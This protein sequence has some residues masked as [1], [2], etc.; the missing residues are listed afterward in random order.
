MKV[1]FITTSL[2]INNGAGHS[3]RSYHI[4]TELCSF[5][6]V[7]VLSCNPNGV[8]FPL[9]KE[10]R[11]VNSY[12]GHIDI[13]W[14]KYFFGFQ[15]R[16]NR[17]LKKI[18]DTGC[19]D[20]IFIRYYNTALRLGALN[21]KNLILDC[22]DCYMELLA[23]Q[24]E[25]IHLKG[26]NGLKQKLSFWFRAYNY[27]KN[28]KKIK[29]VFFAKQ[30]SQMPWMDN[31]AIFPNKISY[32][33]ASAP[34]VKSHKV[35]VDTVKILFIGVLTY[36]PNHEGLYY[37]VNNV[38]PRVVSVCP[39]AILKIVGLGLP[40]EYF[41]KWKSDPSIQI[42][43]YVNDIEQVYEDVDISIVP[44]YKGSGT[45]IKVVESLMRAKTM[46]ISP[47]AHRGYEDSL[48]DNQALFVASTVELYA[49][50]LITLINDK[51]KRIKM[52]EIGRKAVIAHY[53]IETSPQYFKDILCDRSLQ[54]G[55]QCHGLTT[56]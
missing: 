17:D 33:S 51:E 31:F 45:H 4:Y 40:E 18:L 25:D 9:L 13:G 26:V 19:Y 48:F 36:A 52:G 43:G 1:L 41:I 23:Q 49:S 55:K 34:P 37:F 5:A 14:Q 50:Q 16:L 47:L 12:V 53:T 10:F 2:P 21:L 8:S 42:C 3:I 20:H 15:K 7:D 29:R 44:V 54:E 30:S 46:V 32:R 39:Q 28:I 6:D 22:D 11:K 56:P 35:S 24:S 27:F 38:W